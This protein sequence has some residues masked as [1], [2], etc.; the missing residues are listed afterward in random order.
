LRAI[1]S[2][3]HYILSSKQKLL[4]LTD[5][6]NLV[7]IKKFLMKKNRHL[8]WFEVLADVKYQMAHIQGALNVIADY[9]SRTEKTQ[10]AKPKNAL[11]CE[12]Y[13]RNI[14]NEIRKETS[15]ED[16]FLSY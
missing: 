1:E 9:L 5:H 15:E 3:R 12:L 16:L 14:V 7:S 4:I 8:K 2:N 13:G 6:A 10:T 11:L